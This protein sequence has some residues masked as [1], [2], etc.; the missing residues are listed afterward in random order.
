ML[1]IIYLDVNVKAICEDNRYSLL[2]AAVDSYSSSLEAQ[3]VI[4]DRG[5]LIKKSCGV[6]VVGSRTT[7]IIGL[8]YNLPC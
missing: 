1:C 6:V 8:Y 4:P 7:T 3:H 2:V 5:V